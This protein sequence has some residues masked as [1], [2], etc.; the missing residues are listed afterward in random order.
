[1]YLKNYNLEVPNSIL[2]LKDHERFSIYEN[3]HFVFD[4]IKDNVFVITHFNGKKS[5]GT[6]P[7]NQDAIFKLFFETTEYKE[8]SLKQFNNL[9][10]FL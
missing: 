6:P 9:K 10:I 8:C 4:Q 7:Y 1:M 5:E 3:E 2:I